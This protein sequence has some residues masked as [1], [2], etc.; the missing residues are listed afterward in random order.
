MSRPADC[1]TYILHNIHTKANVLNIE[2]PEAFD[3]VL[4]ISCIPIH[5]FGILR[6][7]KDNKSFSP[8]AYDASEAITC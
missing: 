7:N 1:T 2:A 8:A 6:E 3:V 5:F 4:K